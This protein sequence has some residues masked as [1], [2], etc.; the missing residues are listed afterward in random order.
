MR[1]RSKVFA[2]LGILVFYIGSVTGAYIKGR[3]DA[4]ASNSI[5]VL[6]LYKKEVDSNAAIDRGVRRL[7]KSDLDNALYNWLQYE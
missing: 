2:I 3:V 7:D 5:K 6:E 1:I 4:N